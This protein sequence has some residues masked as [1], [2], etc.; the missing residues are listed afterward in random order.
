[1]PDYLW[2]CP[3]ISEYARVRLNLPEWLSFTFLLCNTL[4]T[5]T[6]G[7]L[8]QRLSNTRSH[9]LE[10]HEIV[11]L[12]REIVFFSTEVGNIW[13]IFSILNKIFLQLRFQICCYLWRPKGTG[14]L[15]LYKPFKI[16]FIIE[17]EALIGSSST[18]KLQKS[19]FR[20]AV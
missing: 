6:P 3:N 17:S 7:Y 20:L 15:N 1:M 9:S 5:W 19:I 13:F 10:E 2:I 18:Q 4:P 11:F 12:K 8:F 16:S 14:T